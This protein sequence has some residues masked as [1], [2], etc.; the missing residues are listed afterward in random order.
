M[1]LYSTQ[2]YFQA[3]SSPAALTLQEAGR[4]RA[5][6]RGYVV[7][8]KNGSAQIHRREKKS[9]SIKPLRISS[10]VSTIIL[11]LSTCDNVAQESTYLKN[12]ILHCKYF[13]MLKILVLFSDTFLAIFPRNKNRPKFVASFRFLLKLL[14]SFC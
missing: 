7:S 1:V 5:W 6:E 14:S 10:S 4:D 13:R 2:L 11:A 9:N 12:F 8:V 3:L